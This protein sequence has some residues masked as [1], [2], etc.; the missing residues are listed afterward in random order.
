VLETLPVMILA[1]VGGRPESRPS[2]TSA[3]IRVRQLKI[4]ERQWRGDGKKAAN[5]ELI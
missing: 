2:Q 4:V 1:F 5:V 3:S